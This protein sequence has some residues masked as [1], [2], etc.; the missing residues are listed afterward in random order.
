ML[1]FWSD[2]CCRQD[3]DFSQELHVYFSRTIPGLI[4][5]KLQQRGFVGIECVCLTGLPAVQ[6]CLL[7]KM[8]D[9]SWKGELDNGDHRLLS[10]S[11]LVYTKNGQKFHSQNCKKLYLQFLIDYKVY[12]KEKVMLPSGTHASVPTFFCVLLNFPILFIFNKWN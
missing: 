5:H 11:R 9:A 4:L 6:I 7:L 10:S 2:I 3:D 8:N 12:L 1:E